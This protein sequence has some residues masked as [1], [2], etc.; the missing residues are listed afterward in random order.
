LIPIRVIT[1]ETASFEGLK[2]E[3]PGILREAGAEMALDWHRHTLPQAFEP[4]ARRRHNHRPRSRRYKAKKRALARKGIVR[5]GGQADNV[6]S[7]ATEQSLETLANVRPAR[8]KIT[9]SMI[10]PRY[11][12]RPVGEEITRMSRGEEKRADRIMEAEITKRVKAFRKL[13]KSS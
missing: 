4:S 9:V 2:R 1:V 6:F 5:K 8:G 12:T 11:I 3:M 7:G 13:K 10:G